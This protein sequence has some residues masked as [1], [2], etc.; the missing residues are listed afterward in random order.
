MQCVYPRAAAG[1]RD[2]LSTGLNPN[3]KCL[4]RRRG[5]RGGCHATESLSF[6]N[7]FFRKFFSKFFANYFLISK[8][9]L[10]MSA[11]ANTPSSNAIMAKR[12]DTTPKPRAPATRAGAAARKYTDTSTNAGAELVDPN[13]PLN[14]KQKLFVKFWA[15]GESISTASA[16]AG[17][18]DAATFAYRMTR[19]PNVLAMYSQLKAKYEEAGQMSRKK[20]MDGLLDAAEMAKLMAEPSTMVQAWKTIGQMCGYFAPVEHRM[21]VDV[22]GNVVIDRLNNLSDAE[23]LKMITQPGA[24]LPSLLGPDE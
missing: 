23:L 22:T 4:R 2:S 17:Y 14:D 10:T 20:V 21:K 3:P 1:Q 9:E 5:T 6:F 13:K 24:A 12:R 7:F 8:L 16:K 19:M 15:E 11:R 18:N